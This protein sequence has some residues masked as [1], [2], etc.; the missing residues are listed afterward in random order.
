[1]TQPPPEPGPYGPPPVH[2]Q[3]APYGPPPVS[4]LSPWAQDVFDG[5]QQGTSADFPDAFPNLAFGPEAVLHTSDQAYRIDTGVRWKKRRP[6][7]R[8]DSSVST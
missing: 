3:P 2:G 8:P 7:S 5:M 1:M 6:G 4:T